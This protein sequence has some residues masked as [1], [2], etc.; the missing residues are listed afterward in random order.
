MVKEAD[1]WYY[2]TSTDSEGHTSRHYTRYS[3][4]VVDMDLRT[5]YVS[6]NRE[7]MLT[8]AADHVGL[9]DIDFESEAFNRGFNL[10]CS[11]KEFAYKLIDARMEQFIVDTGGDYGIA[12]AGASALLYCKR[13]PP[14]ELGPLF[15][16]AKAFVDH[17]PPLV[18]NEYGTQAERGGRPAGAGTG[19]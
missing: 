17:I 5:P 16:T 13:V 8:L 1:Y 10:K 2:T 15:D 19:G 14:S 6:I 3:V 9:R 12:F 4:A 7:N 18:W 11:D